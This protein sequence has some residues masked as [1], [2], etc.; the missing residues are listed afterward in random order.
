MTADAEAKLFV[1][2]HEYE[3]SRREVAPESPTGQS[4]RAKLLEAIDE[5]TDAKRTRELEAQAPADER[6]VAVLRAKAAVCDAYLTQRARL[7]A[8]EEHGQ[9]LTKEH[10]AGAQSL[11]DAVT[12]LR[13]LQEKP[14]P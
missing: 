12:T 1:A 10:F 7:D 8:L 11:L 13:R 4:A 5:Y 3:V 2:V 6:L 14:S 9:R